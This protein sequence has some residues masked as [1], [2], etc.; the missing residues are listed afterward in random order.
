MFVSRI[1]SRKTTTPVHLR[2]N[3]DSALS[4]LMPSA[5]MPIHRHFI[6]G[7]ASLYAETLALPSSSTFVDRVLLTRILSPAFEDCDVF[8]PD[9]LSSEWSR[10]NHEEL[11]AWTGVDVAEGVQEEGGVKY[12]F[13]MWS[14][15][16][17][18]T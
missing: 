7:G 11:R 15:G 2:S 5:E 6:I 12:E 9:F 4:L 3:V 14:R 18:S 1:G 16:E 13:Q 8:M 17:P 10:A